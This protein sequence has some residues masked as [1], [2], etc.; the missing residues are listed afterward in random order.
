[1]AAGVEVEGAGFA[2][3]LHAGFQGE[4]VA[5]AAVAGV[6]AGYEIFPGGR[7]SAGAGDDVIEGQFAGRQHGGAV[8]A[9]VAIAQQNV[10]AR[11]SAALVW[12][13]AILQQTNDRGHTHGDARGVEEV[14]IFLFGH[15]HA[16]ENQDEGTAGGADIDRLIGGIQDEHGRVQR[17]AV[18][19]AMHGGGRK[20]AGSVSSGKS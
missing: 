7:A 18:A 6:A 3:E 1:M 5:F 8:L 20:Q 15:G 10:L 11:K 14:S 4:L 12:D 16:F 13:T 2:H 19:V 17:M 9:G